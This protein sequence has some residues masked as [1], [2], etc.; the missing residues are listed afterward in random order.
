MASRIDTLATHRTFK[1]AGIEP[2]DAEVIIEAINRAD[3]RLA[4]KDDLALVRSELGGEIRALNSQLT[5]MKWF[6]GINMAM[7]TGLVVRLFSIL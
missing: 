4:T 3:D 5:A 2:A 7:T 1:E 6:M